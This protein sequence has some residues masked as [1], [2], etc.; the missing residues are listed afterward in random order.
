[1][2]RKFAIGPF[3]KLSPVLFRAYNCL[4]R[5]PVHTLIGEGVGEERGFLH[6]VPLAIFDSLVVWVEA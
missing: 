2:F 6:V 4:Q 3:C 5:W 1:M